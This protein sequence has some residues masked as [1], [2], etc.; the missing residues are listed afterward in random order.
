MVDKNN[1]ERLFKDNYSELY[2]LA[3]ALLK[4]EDMA[5]DAV[6][7]VFANLLSSNRSDNKG[8]GYL[9]RCVR[10]RCLN[11]IREMPIRESIERLISTETIDR[12]TDYHERREEW[13]SKI[14]NIILND[15]TPQCSKIMQLRYET[16]LPYADI[17]KLLGISRTAVYKHLRNGIDLIRKKLTL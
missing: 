8:K 2:S 9:V 12:E 6:H 3:F 13:L 14:H 5:R 10:N 15:L 4:D 16:G 1:I 7:D 11:V 17:T